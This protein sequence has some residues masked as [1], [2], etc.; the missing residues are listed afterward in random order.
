MIKRRR[1]GKPSRLLLITGRIGLQEVRN[2]PGIPLTEALFPIPRM[3]G[4]ATQSVILPTRKLGR[5][6]AAQRLLVK[7]FSQKAA[8]I[9]FLILGKIVIHPGT[10]S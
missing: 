3:T 8:K 4:I 10:L 2:F 5:D 7:L 1:T 9:S 6:K